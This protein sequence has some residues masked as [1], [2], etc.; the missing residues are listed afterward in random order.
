MIIN[1]LLITAG[2]SLGRIFEGEDPR[3]Y[4][5]VPEDCIAFE[6]GGFRLMEVDYAR[7]GWDVRNLRFNDDGSGQHLFPN[8]EKPVADLDSG[9]VKTFIDR[10]DN[11]GAV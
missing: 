9:Q 10:I 8:T 1:N 2:G 7:S 4:C 5:F 11:V 3:T 6:G